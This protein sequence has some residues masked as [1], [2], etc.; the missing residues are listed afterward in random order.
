MKTMPGNLT[1]VKGI[2]AL[3]KAIGIKKGKMDFAVIYSDKICNAAA[4]YTSNKV[5]GAPLY[6]TKEH[7]KDGKAKAIVINS[8]VANVCTGEK[9]I[10]D[11]EK[12]CELA[13]KE[14]GIKAEGVLVASTGMIGAYLPMDKIMKGVKGIKK[15]LSKES[16]VGEA[17]LTTDLVKKEICVKEDNFTIGAVAKGSG[18]IHPNM[19]T[20]LAFICTDAEISSDK[21]QIMLK[22]TV[23]ESFNMMSVDMDTST[24]DMCILLANG[25]AGKVNEE[26]FQ[27]ALDFV[28]KELAKKIAADGE[29]A[30]KLISVKVKNAASLG[31]AK[32]LSKSIICSNLFKCAAYG[33]DPNWGRILCA[34]GNT[35]IEFDE[36]KVDVYFGEKIIVKN[37]VTANFNYEEIKKIMSKKELFV[38]ID[39]HAGKEEA[40]AY[41]CDMTEDYI[42][43]NAHYHT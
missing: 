7:L 35:G 33:N 21:L 22:K 16:M 36:L 11:A 3:G 29:G 10:K 13:G 9:G 5:K 38:T 30:T 2:T 23:G 40:T 31:D 34:M 43:I 18:M 41:G 28:C 39:M 25:Y 20:M 26:K 27:K 12:M 24:S 15:E 6:V 14:L 4:V 17:I 32:K 42:K 19:A 37:G 8:G 1:N